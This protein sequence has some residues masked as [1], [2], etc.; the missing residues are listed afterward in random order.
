MTW[1]ICKKHIYYRTAGC[2]ERVIA[3]VK[4]KEENSLQQGYKYM[5]LQSIHS[6]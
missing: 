5:S 4:K 2:C 6:C 1:Y 3:G